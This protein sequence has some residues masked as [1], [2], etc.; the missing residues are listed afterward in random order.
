MQKAANL[1]LHK[2]IRDSFQSFLA[3]QNDFADTLKL[4]NTHTTKTCCIC[5]LSHLSKGLPSIHHFEY[6]CQK[7]PDPPP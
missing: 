7:H 3:R 6:I 4:Q 1:P 5:Y 2:W